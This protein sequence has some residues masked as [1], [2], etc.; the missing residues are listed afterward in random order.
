MVFHWSLSDKTTPKVFRN[1]LNILTG[2]NNALVIIIL[3]L[4]EFFSPA[5][6]DGL[7]LEFELQQDFLSF[8]GSS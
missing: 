8:L 2:L 7:S 4:W 6:V 5:L 3:L 1:H